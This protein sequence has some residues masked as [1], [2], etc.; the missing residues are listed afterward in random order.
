[1]T[2]LEY[3]NLLIEKSLQGGFPCYSGGCKYRYGDKRCVAGWL[4]PDD[5]YD[6]KFE[7]NSVNI[8]KDKFGYDI[9]KN[10]EGLSLY[11][12]SDIQYYHDINTD[13]WN[14]GEFINFL[15]KEL[16]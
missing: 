12:L 6:I 8:L 14:H 7:F 2:K 13:E 11:T 16:N 3:K 4:I 1:M 10:V 9:S 5:E 15:E